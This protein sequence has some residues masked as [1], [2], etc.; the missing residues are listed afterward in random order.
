M[1]DSS[2]GIARK[3]K[4]GNFTYH[5]K[6]GKRVRDPSKLKR[7]RSLAIPPAWERVWISPQANG[8]L[9]ATGID[10]KGRKQYKYH[11]TW[12]TVRDEAKFERLLAFAEVLPRIRAQV[13]QDMDRPDL[14]REKVL[15]TIVRL[16]EV[17]LI[18][19]GNEEYAQE[20]KSFGLT[21]MRNRHVEVEGSN[22]RFQF[23]GKS[24]RKHTV[25]VSDRRVA[26][27]I[28]KCQDLPGQQLFEYENPAGEVVAIVSEDVNHYLQQITGQPFTAKDFRTWAGTVLAAIALGKM[29]EVD[30]Q[31][32]AK[33]N[34]V[35]AIEAVARLLGNTVAI[36]RK[37]YIHPAIPTSYLD[38]T[39]AR[40]L[41]VEADS[42]ITQHLHE[43]KPE[44]AAVITLLRQE[45]AQRSQN[46]NASACRSFITGGPTRSATPDSLTP[47]SKPDRLHRPVPPI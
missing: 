22:V 21:T 26:R 38:G 5:D 24:G 7:I 6:E 45:L 39:L 9:Q 15:A 3:R 36:C 2:P 27:V 40:T 47:S 8:H 1:S 32:L 34:I 41:R 12:R 42:Q 30:S 33:R 46:G 28:Q 10:A 25:E 4:G 23:R 17:S 29:E 18:R 44:E 35:T 43:L 16:L 37:C 14:S 19:I 13:A 20:N 11:P 31:T